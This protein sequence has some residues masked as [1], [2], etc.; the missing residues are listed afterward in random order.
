[1]SNVLE[2]RSVRKQFSSHL[3]VAEASF[4]LVRGE[5]FSLIGP[6]GCGKT[7]TLRMIAGLEELS[8]GTILLNGKEVQ[9]LPPHL[10]D[11]STVFQN[12]ALFP[13]L[14]VQGQR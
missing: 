11:V 12:Y 9:S 8:A 2:L 1:M 3:A 7:T 4:E 14:T 5:F 10:R 13:H 6:S